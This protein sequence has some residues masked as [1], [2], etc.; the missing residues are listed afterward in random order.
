M[1]KPTPNPTLPKSIFKFLNKLQKNNNR[2]WFNDHKEEY[3][4]EDAHFKQFAEALLNEMTQYD[5]IE[6][7]RTYRIY[8]DVRFSKDK[9]PYKN[10]F[11]GG[12]KRA[13]KWLRGSYYFHIQ[14]GASMVGGGFWGPNAAD[15]KRI[16]QEIAADAE[17]LRKI[18]ADPV[19]VKTFGNME[20]TQLKTAPRDYPKDHPNVDLLRYK[21]FLLRRN[22][23]DEEVFA[24]DFLPKLVETF[25]AMRPFLD[26]MSDVLTT[27]ANG[28]LIE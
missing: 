7:M 17:P 28:V 25:R 23:T 11:A 9:T 3:L 2:P 8:R 26:Y 20:G 19:F 4:V 5:N 14:P 18:L 16:R 24:D 12:M 13:T 27:D 22:F 10:N 21:Q 15:L 6:S 1:A